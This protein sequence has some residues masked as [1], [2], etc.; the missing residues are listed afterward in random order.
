MLALGIDDSVYLYN[1]ETT[2]TEKLLQLEGDD[3]VCSVSWIQ[4][5]PFLA[6][7]TTTGEIELWDCVKRKKVRVM[8]RHIRRVGA[9]CWNSHILTS[10]CRF[11][12]VKFDL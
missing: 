5:G 10:G 6:V 9:L 11:L 3:Y 4:E 2:E 12:S 7:G 1:S 8:N